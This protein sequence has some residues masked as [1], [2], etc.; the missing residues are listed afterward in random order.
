MQTITRNRAILIA[1][2]FVV[3]ASGVLYKLYSIQIIRNDAFR[4]RAE[5]QQQKTT[6]E[7]GRRGSIY[8][9]N[10][11]KLALNIEH[12]SL[13]VN[14]DRVKDVA[15]I[16]GKLSPILDLFPGEIERRIL[17]AGRRSVIA[18]ELNSVQAEQIR[19]LGIF[20]FGAPAFELEK[21]S[22][23]SYPGGVLAA[24]VVGFAGWDDDEQVGR[25]GIELE[26]DD[27]LQGEP[28][29]VYEVRDGMGRGFV[30]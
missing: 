3:M 6:V 16:A 12:H 27:I 25:E 21:H 5:E 13:I 20:G 22:R 30:R 23:R 28:T 17:K 8:D 15:K 4:I 18:R 29:T 26:L 9:R 24:H 11:H 2:M 7:A 10:G 14:P 19:N 1:V